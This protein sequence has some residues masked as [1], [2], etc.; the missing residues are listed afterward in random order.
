MPYN[1]PYKLPHNVLYNLPLNLLY[2]LPQPSQPPRRNRRSGQAV[3]GHRTRRLLPCDTPYEADRPAGRVLG[4]ALGRVLSPALGRILG[5][6]RRRPGAQRN[7]SSAQRFRAARHADYF[8][9][10]LL[11]LRPAPGTASR[12]TAGMIGR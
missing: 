2:N 10:V 5:R 6:A 3:K 8:P 9:G 4:L 1:L 12:S 11:A 7:P